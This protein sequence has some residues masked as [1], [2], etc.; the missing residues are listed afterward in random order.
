MT[1]AKYKKKGISLPI[2]I[3]LIIGV[4]LLVSLSVLFISYELQE[5]PFAVEILSYNYAVVDDVGLVL[6]T[7]ALNFG[8]APPLATVKRG[9]NIS[10]SRPARVHI[11]V[12]TTNIAV[13]KNDFIVMPGISQPVSFVLLIPEFANRGNYTG[14]IT[15]LFY[16]I[17]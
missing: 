7:D 14:N 6:D 12:D 3:S 2:V 5:K 15:L 10:T 4:A 11:R 16:D 13:D 9:I 1:H 8:E 17:E